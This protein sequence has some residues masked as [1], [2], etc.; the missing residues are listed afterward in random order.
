[1]ALLH[2]DLSSAS[3]TFFGFGAEEQQMILDSLDQFT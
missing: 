1:M 2:S 3:N